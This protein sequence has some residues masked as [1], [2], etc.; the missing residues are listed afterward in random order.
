MLDLLREGLTNEQ[1]AERLGIST[2]GAKY[3]VSQILSKL[4][5]ASRE[6][7]AAWRP[8]AA[9]PWWAAGLAM[10]GWPLRRLSLA[11]A[12]KATGAL[13]LL[14]TAAGIAL[15]AWALLATEGTDDGAAP[16]AATPP[17]RIAFASYR[18]G[19]YEIY[20]I[21]ADGSGETRLTDDPEDYADISPSWSPGGEM[22]VFLR[23]VSAERLGVYVMDADGSNRR[24]L[25]DM[26]GYGGHQAIFTPDGR[27]VVYGCAAILDRPGPTSAGLCSVNVDGSGSV[28]LFTP[29]TYLAQARPSGW[30]RDGRL[31]A[32]TEDDLRFTRVY[33]AGPDGAGRR[34]LVEGLGYSSGGVWS[35]DGRSIAFTCAEHRIGGGPAP[36]PSPPPNPIGICLADADGSNV[37]R[38]ATDGSNPTW[39]PDGEWIA[40]E[41]DADIYVM[42]SDGSD[43]RRITG[44]RGKDETPAWSPVP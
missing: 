17:G 8:E 32:Y 14:G 41:F 30:S 27:S 24:H 37:R 23:A 9:R 10:L 34:R 40:F 15:L 44:D 13:V 7:A 22:L 36:P 19:D 42:R 5:V 43:R 18:D 33:V 6:E 3:H 2:D 16:A 25:A 21:N 20:L 29:P 28:S 39:S 1:V 31:L 12:A 4:G 11:A 38:I 35:P 26:A